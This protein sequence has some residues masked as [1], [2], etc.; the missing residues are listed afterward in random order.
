MSEHEASPL[1]F[2]WQPVGRTNSVDDPE[3]GPSPDAT[4]GV[5]L[6]LPR[7]AP[8]VEVK[9]PTLPISPVLASPG[10][11]YLLGVGG[12]GFAVP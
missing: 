8:L 12:L 4:K 1:R 10:Y 9:S 6:K 2:R 5:G 11:F 7:N 3:F